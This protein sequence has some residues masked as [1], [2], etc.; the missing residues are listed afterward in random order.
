MTKPKPGSKKRSPAQKASLKAATSAAS[1][2]FKLKIATGSIN[3]R[4]TRASAPL[5]G[6]QSIKKQLAETIE[7]VIAE[8]KR[9]LEA[10]G[11]AN[12]A[13]INSTVL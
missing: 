2:T 4:L 7:T 13:E 1:W 9:T 11:H 8:K 5:L 10:I 3:S 12:R 6:L